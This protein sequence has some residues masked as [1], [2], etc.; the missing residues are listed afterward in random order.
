MAPFLQ[1]ILLRFC[2]TNS[3]RAGRW[4]T[5]ETR[6]QPDEWLS[7]GI[8]FKFG[9]LVKFSWIFS[10]FSAENSRVSWNWF[11][12]KTKPEMNFH[13]FIS[14]GHAE[15]GIH[16]K[17][18]NSFKQIIQLILSISSDGELIPSKSLAIHPSLV[19]IHEISVIPPL[20]LNFNT[21]SHR[22]RPGMY[23]N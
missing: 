13:P 22:F 11:S 10:D 3:H 17:V 7:F 8:N 15:I 14:R 18:R 23:L 21:L 5:D 9:V 6:C 4:W 12:A 19:R 16:R 2:Y 20:K 1:L